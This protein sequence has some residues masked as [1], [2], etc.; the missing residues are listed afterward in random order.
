MK[1]TSYQGNSSLNKSCQSNFI[2]G[3]VF[4]TSD[5]DLKS[6]AAAEQVDLDC[7]PTGENQTRNGELFLT[8]P[9]QK[10][11][12]LLSPLVTRNLACLGA[13]LFL[14]YLIFIY[15]CEVCIH[16]P[17]TDCVPPKGS[18]CSSRVHVAESLAPGPFSGRHLLTATD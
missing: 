18:L 3:A 15:S 9:I 10:L 5:M 7:P 2:P 13:F 11:P 1:F 16:L 17:A 14:S 12:W 6:S 8:L 4:G